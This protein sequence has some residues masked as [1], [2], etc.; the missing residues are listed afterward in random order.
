[1]RKAVLITLILLISAIAVL[2]EDV[3]LSRFRY[4]RGITVSCDNFLGYAQF[5][6]S[7]DIMV[8]SKGLQNIYIDSEYY[9]EAASSSEKRG[10]FV[11]DSNADSLEAL[12]STLDK[13]TETYYVVSKPQSR[14][15]VHLKNPAIQAFDTVVITLKDSELDNVEFSQGAMK[16]EPRV[17]KN[18]FE[19]RYLFGRK[20]SADNIRI[21]IIFENIL[22]VA[23]IQF[24]DS[25]DKSSI[26]FFINDDCNREYKLYYGGFGGSFMASRR[27]DSGKVIV[28]GLSP[29]NLNPDYDRDFDG[30]SVSNEEDNCISVKNVDQK[31][32]N[33]NGIGD[34]CED[35]DDDGVV[36]AEDNCPDKSNANQM[37]LDKDEAG[38]ACDPVDG[39]LSEQNKWFFYIFA[40]MIV[41]LFGFIGYK[42][43][44]KK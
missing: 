25:D 1:M 19:Y 12:K 43:L 32:I 34:A 20:I 2:G 14:L 31:D 17:I 8:K 7:E 9:I 44:K 39:R 15:D 3:N 40:A 38:N 26:Y 18:N 42:L 10:W 6:P 11:K 27:H 22:K 36:N 35:F 4:L 16:L 30:D 23:D 41:S 24:F 13:D 21:Q 37:D 33:Y 28:A 29:E 5:E